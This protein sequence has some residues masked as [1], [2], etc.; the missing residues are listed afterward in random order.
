[1]LRRGRSIV[2]FSDPPQITWPRI[3]QPSITFTLKCDDTIPFSYRFLHSIWGDNS[4]AAGLIT[5]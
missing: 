4:F 3:L 2:F 1:M 5:F